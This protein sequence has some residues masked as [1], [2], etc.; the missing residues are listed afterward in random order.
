M[1]SDIAKFMNGAGKIH[2]R[3]MNIKKTTAAVSC[4]I[5][6]R[7][8]FLVLRI[9]GPIFRER[10]PYPKFSAWEPHTVK[11][12]ADRPAT[13]NGRERIPGNLPSCKSFMNNL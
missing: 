5:H 7:L 1:A 4:A 2:E 10:L 9:S 3:F 11:A 13:S 8:R 12:K 6:E